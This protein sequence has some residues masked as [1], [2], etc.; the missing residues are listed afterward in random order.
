MVDSNSLTITVTAYVVNP[1]VTGVTS[2]G[3]TTNA[4]ITGSGFTQNGVVILYL[5]IYSDNFGSGGGGIGTDAFAVDQ[6][7]ADGNGDVDFTA[8]G[9]TWLQLYNNQAH[10][11]LN[12]SETFSFYFE[13]LDSSSGMAATPGIITI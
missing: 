4:T 8:T 1:Q 9:N 2:G 5:N 13:L 10:T 7:Q 11:G 6:V 3:P 12:S